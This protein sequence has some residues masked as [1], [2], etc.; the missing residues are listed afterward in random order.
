MR[1]TEGASC[2]SAHDITLI[3][4]QISFPNTGGLKISLQTLEACAY[5]LQTMSRI[6]GI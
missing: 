6:D 1:S 5:R 2:R 4:H 3:S